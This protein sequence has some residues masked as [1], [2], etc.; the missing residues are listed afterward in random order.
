M[1][2]RLQASD[3]SA[4]EYLYDNY[5]AALLGIIQ[6]ILIDRELAEDTL[7][8]VYVRVWNNARKYNKN[9]GRLFTWMANIARNAAIDVT[10]SKSF[11][12]SSKV[13]SIDNNVHQT[14]DDSSR[15][16]P[17]FIGLKDKVENL[18]PRHVEIIEILYFKGYTQAEAA[19]ELDMPL[20]TVKSR[21]KIALRE[22]KKLLTILL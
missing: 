5:S 1:V 3:K 12:K 4:I 10:R 20:G 2:T 14:A 7:Q 9:K 17:E 21:V 8:E 22:L 18:D 13:Q 6:R 11:K 16:R 15:T 19:E